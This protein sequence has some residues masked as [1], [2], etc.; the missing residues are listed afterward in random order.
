M[1]PTSIAN[2]G[3]G[4]VE[5]GLTFGQDIGQMSDRAVKIVWPVRHGHNSGRLTTHRGWH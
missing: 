1:P 5:D 2:I 3:Q 4:G